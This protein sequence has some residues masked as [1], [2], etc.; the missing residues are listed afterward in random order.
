[1]SDD[2]KGHVELDQMSVQQIIDA[3]KKRD[4]ITV[5]DSRFVH[6]LSPD[7]LS[8]ED[9]AP[10]LRNLKLGDIKRLTRLAHSYLVDARTK[11][12]NAGAGC[13]G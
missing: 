11:S 4:D 8:R 7:V 2:K 13:G 6:D 10:N 9:T 12:P 3:L 1:M 5:R